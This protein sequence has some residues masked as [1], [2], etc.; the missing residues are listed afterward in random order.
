M[1][2]SHHGAN[3]TSESG[4]RGGGGGAIPHWVDAS[5]PGSMHLPKTIHSKLS[6]ETVGKEL[7]AAQRSRSASKVAHRLQLTGHDRQTVCMPGGT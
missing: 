1:W 6:G 7:T 2:W 5:S 3:P 4:A